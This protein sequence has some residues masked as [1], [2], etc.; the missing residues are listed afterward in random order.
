MDDCPHVRLAN[1]RKLLKKFDE[2]GKV[3]IP[4]DEWS[5]FLP[6]HLLLRRLGWHRVREISQAPMDD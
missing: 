2:S 4:L 3:A 1:S 6:V 5:S